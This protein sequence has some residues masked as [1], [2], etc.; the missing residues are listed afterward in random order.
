MKS[1]RNHTRDSRAGRGEHLELAVGLRNGREIPKLPSTAVIEVPA[2]VGAVGIT[3]L[4]AGALPE[5]IVAVLTARPAQQEV[6]VRA[7]MLGDRQLALQALVLD[8]LVPDSATW[9][10]I[11][12]DAIAADPSTLQRFSS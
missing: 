2:V 8:P 9:R 3:G 11:L 10:A 7:A 6:T 4:E 1:M 5:A 12:D